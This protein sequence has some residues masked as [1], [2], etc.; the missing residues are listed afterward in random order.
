MWTC[1]YIVGCLLD[2]DLCCVS[3]TQK[4]EPLGIASSGGDPA[5]TGHCLCP[6][7]SLSHIECYTLDFGHIPF[8]EPADGFRTLIEPACAS[9]LVNI[10]LAMSWH[11][12]NDL[13]GQLLPFAGD[14]E[15]C[16]SLQ[17]RKL[18]VCMLTELGNTLTALKVCRWLLS[19]EERLLQPSV[20]SWGTGRQASWRR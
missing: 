2:L 15:L 12:H 3:F 10:L 17:P 14:T 7:V 19:C 8:L 9:L 1:R 4:E 5:E 20:T 11:P 18:Y 6:V 16:M 13:L